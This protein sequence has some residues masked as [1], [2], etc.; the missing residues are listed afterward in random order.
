MP[1]AVPA[2]PVILP[3]PA[4]YALEDG[5]IDIAERAS[6]FRLLS[7]R[8]CPRSSPGEIVVCAPEDGEKYRYRPADPSSPTAMQEISDKLRL[9][10]GPVEGDIVQ[11]PTLHGA[12]SIGV[13]FRIRF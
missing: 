12:P 4:D 1:D 7:E 2:D 6:T 13:R 9:T 10:L 3:A 8:E 5:G 11:M